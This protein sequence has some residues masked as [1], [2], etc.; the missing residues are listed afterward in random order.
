LLNLGHRA[1]YAAEDRAALVAG[2]VAQTE[3]SGTAR[4][5]FSTQ[6]MAPPAAADNWYRRMLE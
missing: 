1:F 5:P 2:R 6:L 4:L 3:A